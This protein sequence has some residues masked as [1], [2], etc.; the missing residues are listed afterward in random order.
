MDLISLG[1]LLFAAVTV[2][3]YYVL[4]LRL[5][6]GWLL[7]ASVFFYLSADLRCGLSRAP[8]P[9]VA[10]EPPMDTEVTVAHPAKAESAIEVGA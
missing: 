3:V 10:T 8:S 9:M 2:C 4:P 7:M 1:F 5:R 6:P